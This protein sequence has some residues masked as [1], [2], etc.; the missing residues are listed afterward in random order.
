MFPSYRKVN[1]LGP[2]KCRLNGPIN[3][4]GMSQSTKIQFTDPINPDPTYSLIGQ[5]ILAVTDIGDIFAR[6]ICS[7]KT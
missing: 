1:V 2:M 4:L 6:N 3:G 5:Y 7:C